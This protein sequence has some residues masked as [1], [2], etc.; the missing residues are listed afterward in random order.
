MGSLRILE[1]QLH[2]TCAMYISSE[3]DQMMSLPFIQMGARPKEC[4]ASRLKNVTSNPTVLYI[5]HA[6]R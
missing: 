2:R 4:S 3:F 5:L 1:L 6:I